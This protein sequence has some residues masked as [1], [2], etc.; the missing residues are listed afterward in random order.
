MKRKLL[1]GIVGGLLVLLALGL[2]ITRTQ[3]TQVQFGVNGIRYEVVT[4]QRAQELGLG[5]RTNLPDDYGML[6]VFPNA[7]KYGFWMKDMR[8]P[9]DII[10]LSDTGAI[11]SIDANVSPTTYPKAFYPPSPVRYVLETR[12]GLA[13]AKNWVVGSTVALPPPY[14]Y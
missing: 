13:M 3:P 9:I 6:F 2:Y 8:V 7:D 14:S 11:I 5:G 1:F 12:A 4:T 10:W